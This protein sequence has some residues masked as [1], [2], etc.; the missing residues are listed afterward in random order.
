MKPAIRPYRSWW[1][2]SADTAFAC[3]PD[4]LHSDYDF[5]GWTGEDARS[6]LSAHNA[7]RTHNGVC[8]RASRR[9]GAAPD[10]PVRREAWGK[11]L[12]SWV[13]HG[14]GAERL[15][16]RRRGCWR[17]TCPSQAR[18]AVTVQPATEA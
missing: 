4:I 11:G 2:S 8:V 5:F 15:V 6:A 17:R 9:K 18:P 13:R 1:R 7:V 16:M 3:Q 10:L 12:H 14:A